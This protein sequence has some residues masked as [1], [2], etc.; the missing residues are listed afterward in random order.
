MALAYFR[1]V[2]QHPI[3]SETKYWWQAAQDGNQEEMSNEDNSEFFWLLIALLGAL[4]FFWWV[5]GSPP[6]KQIDNKCNIDNVECSWPRMLD[7]SKK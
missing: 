6:S 3:Q 2:C 4:G 1:A 5:M 7:K